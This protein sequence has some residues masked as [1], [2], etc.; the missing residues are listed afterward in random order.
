MT[1]DAHIFVK[2]RLKLSVAKCKEF[3][4]FILPQKEFVYT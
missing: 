2:A 4:P 3:A 1:Y